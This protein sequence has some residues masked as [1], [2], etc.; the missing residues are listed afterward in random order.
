MTRLVAPVRK[1]SQFRQYVVCP[2]TSS[3]TAEECL[4]VF[5]VVAEPPRACKYIRLL[6]A[7]LLYCLYKQLT[8]GN[9]RDVF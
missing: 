6:K 4:D 5:A 2:Y 8:T 1:S 9:S 3:G 7:S